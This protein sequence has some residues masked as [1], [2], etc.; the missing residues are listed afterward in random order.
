MH[1]YYMTMRPAG[2]GAQPVYGLVNIE[3]FPA[4]KLIP[5]IQRYAW[6]R[7]DYDRKLTNREAKIYELTPAVYDLRLTRHQI[8]LAIN[9]VEYLAAN[10]DHAPEA[11][12]SLHDSLTNT[13]LL[14]E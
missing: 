3:T 8:E 9:A 11:L 13:L 10:S 14:K 7:V 6:S 5:E 4:P 12:E 2:P 1:S